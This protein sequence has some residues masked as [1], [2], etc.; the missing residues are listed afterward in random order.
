MTESTYNPPKKIN[1]VVIRHDVVAKLFLERCEGLATKGSL[2]KVS[3]TEFQGK[4]I[5]ET[6]V[7]DGTATLTLADGQPLTIEGDSA[8]WDFV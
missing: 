5:R 4:I 8:E 6:H 2:V 3:A 7:A 1:I